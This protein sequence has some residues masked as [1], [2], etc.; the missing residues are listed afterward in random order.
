[1]FTFGGRTFIVNITTMHK[2]QYNLTGVLRKGLWICRETPEFYPYR[3]RKNDDTERKIAT[4][5]PRSD[6]FGEINS[7]DI[8]VLDLLT[9]EL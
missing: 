5:K 2:S 1:M 7:V 4:C 3:E 6:V 8:L 9:S